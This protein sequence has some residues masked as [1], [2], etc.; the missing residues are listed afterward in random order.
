MGTI[1]G[2]GFDSRRLHQFI[3]WIWQAIACLFISR[4]VDGQGPYPAPLPA[5]PR[6]PASLAPEGL[7]SLVAGHF[8]VLAL[9]KAP[10]EFP[11]GG[12][13][14][15]FLAAPDLEPGPAGLPCG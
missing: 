3:K 6:S 13:M 10:N 1:G 8:H 9:T 15:G 12:G 4:T 2:R 5:M 11:G 7:G 14:P